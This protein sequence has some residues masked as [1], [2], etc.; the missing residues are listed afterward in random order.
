MAQTLQQFVAQTADR[1]NHAAAAFEVQSDKFLQVNLGF[2]GSDGNPL[3]FVWM[4]MGSMVAYTGEVTFEREG[5]LEHGF[6]Q[7]MKKA[8]TGEGAEL[9]RATCKPGSRSQLYLADEGK[10]VVL[11]RL[12]GDAVVV[13]G[14]DLL[15]FEP[16][17]KHKITMMRKL[18]GI[19]SGGLF[20]VRLEGHG[21]V[22]ILTHGTP[23]T[24]AVGPDLPPVFSD[25][26][27]TVAWSGNLAPDFHTDVSF[28]TFIGRSSGESFQM[29]FAA[30]NQLGFVVVQPFEEHPPPPPPPQV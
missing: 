27:A 24:L 17:I 20:N 5:V 4:K 18:S 6:K 14:N 21:F 26:Q 22:A 8:F 11:L 2:V 29:K 12:T 19:V 23:I 16:T 28:K 10:R 15:A 3:P 1:P 30:G 13:N 25:P 9:V 7:A